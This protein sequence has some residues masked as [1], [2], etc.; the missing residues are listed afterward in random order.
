MI[1][2]ESLAEALQAFQEQGF[3]NPDIVQISA[4]RTKTAG[5]YH[6]M[7]GQNPVFILTAQK[8]KQDGEYDE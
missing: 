4:A 8:M 2:L 1:A 3:E 7:T 6:M 5:S